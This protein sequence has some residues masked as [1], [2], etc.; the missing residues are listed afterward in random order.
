LAAKL[1]TRKTTLDK[2]VEKYG[3]EEGRKRCH[4]K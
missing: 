1:I 4:E 2:F 3:E